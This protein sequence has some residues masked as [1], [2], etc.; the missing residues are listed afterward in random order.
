MTVVRFFVAPSIVSLACVA[1]A[2]CLLVPASSVGLVTPND[3][4]Y[5]IKSITV[6]FVDK[7]E[8][9]TFS[10]DA[11]VY[12]LSQDGKP[13]ETTLLLKRLDAQTFIAQ[14]RV[15]NVLAP[16]SSFVVYTI[17]KT[18]ETEIE[19]RY[20]GN[21]SAA[22]LAKHGIAEIKGNVASDIIGGAVC[23]VST[24]SQLIGLSKEVPDGSRAVRKLKIVSR[25]LDKKP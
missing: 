13:T 25:E 5:P 19:N 22:T 3:A 1:L 7:G 9:A 6:D 16:G 10:R 18:G 11:D 14:M 8:R 4:D 23:S 15:A 24:L 20:C 21:Y 12:R 17:L 2:G